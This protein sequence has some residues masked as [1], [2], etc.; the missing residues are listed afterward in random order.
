MTTELEYI[1]VLSEDSSFQLIR[2]NP[3]LTGNLKITVNEQ[4]G[5][6]LNSIPANLELA[7]DDFSRF[8]VDTTHSLSSNIYQFFKGGET[9][10]EIIF[11]LTEEVDTTK[12]SKD[13]KDQFDFSNYFSG[14]KYLVSSKYDER[15]SY[16]A[17]LYLK[18]EIPNYF[19]IFKIKDPLN[20]PIDE[21]KADYLA[22]QEKGD[23]LRDLFQKATI[24]KTFDLRPTTKIGKLIRDHRFSPNFPVSPLTVNF[25]EDQYTTWNGIVIDSGVLGSK[26]ELL[27][28]FYRA[29]SPLKFF[30]E[31]ITKGFERN[32]VII[33]N[34]L[35]LEFIFND[36]EAKLYDLDRYI[37]FYVNQIDL[38]TLKVDL[39]RAYAERETWENEPIF[40]R[41]YFEYEEVVVPQSNLNGVVLPYKELNFN[42]SEFSE[43]F[44]DRNKLYFNYLQ[45]RDDRFYLVKLPN[46]SLVESP[47]T[48]NYSNPISVTLAYSGTS[49]TV[50]L[51]NHSFNTDDFVVI[52]SQNTDYSGE[53]FITKLSNNTFSY[54]PSVI[55]SIASA[56]GTVKKEIG[57]GKIRLS[58]TSID[59]G[60]FFGPV[61][62]IFLQDTGAASF[63]A[64]YSSIAIKLKNVLN[65]LD[66]FKLYH[67]NGTKVDALGKYDFYTGVENYPLVQADGSFYAFNDYD[68][69]SGGDT[70]YFN[71]KG[72]V[73]EV[74][75]ALAGAI[76][77]TRNR[78]FIAY[79][80]EDYVFIRCNIP[81]EFDQLHKI[82]FTSPN[83]DYTTVVLGDLQDQNLVNTLVNFTGGSKFAGNRLV[84]NYGHFEKIKNNISNLLVK[85]SNG[86]SSISKISRYFDQIV[87]SNGISRSKRLSAISDYQQKMVIT[88]DQLT[89]PS[90]RYNNFLIKE[91]SRPPLGL[92]SFFPVKDLDFDFLTSTYLNFPQIDLYQN[93]YVPAGLELLMAGVQYKVIGGTIKIGVVQYADGD[94]FTVASDNTKYEIVLGNPTVTYAPNTAV[95]PYSLTYGISDEN[96]EL[97]DFPGFSILKDPDLVQPQDKTEIFTIRDKFINGLTSTEYDY[98]KENVATDFALRS[99]ILPYINKWAI[100]NGK[101]S[102]DNPYRLNTEIVFGRNN[103]SPDHTDRSQNPD[104]FTHEWFYIESSFNYLEDINT[105]KENN[106][107]FDSPLDINKL[108]TDEDYF[109]DYFTY[110]PKVI[111]S[112]EEVD[113]APTQFRYSKLFKNRAGRYET[114]FK[115]FKIQFNDV[116]DPNLLGADGRPQFN[117]QSNR[118]E[119]YKFSCILKP[120]KESFY[121][122]SK[123]PIKYEIIEHRD[124]KFILIV[125]KLYIGDESSIVSY[126]KEKTALYTRDAVTNDLTSSTEFFFADS[127]Y[128]TEFGT[129]LPYQTIL[130]DYRISFNGDGVSNLNYN[131]IYSLKNKKFNTKLDNFSNIKL[132][133]KI[134][135]SQPFI[136][137]TFEELINPQIQNYPSLFSNEVLKPS[138]KKFIGARYNSISTDYFIDEFLG[139]VPQNLNPVISVSAN[140]MQ[141]GL[142]TGNDIK[143]ASPVLTSP[144]TVQAYS[145]P[146]SAGFKNTIRDQFQFFVI[147]GGEQYFERQFENLSFSKFKQYVNSFD[148]FI[149]YSSY[150]YD[151]ALGSEVLEDDANFYLDILAQDEIYK[152][153]QVIPILDEDRPTQFSSIEKLSYVY[154][155]SPLS[156]TLQLNRYKGEYEPISVDLLNCNSTFKFTKNKIVDLSLANVSFNANIKNIMTLL[157]FN[158]IK[159]ADTKILSLESDESYLPKYS[160]IG[161]IAIGT[162][163]YF[164]LNSNWDWGFHHN[165]TT[166]TT[167]ESVSGSL[168]V[169]EDQC[170]LAKILNVPEIIELENFIITTLGV[171]ETLSGVNPAQVEMVIKEESN[172]VDGIININT[173]LTRYFI[174]NGIEAKF[175]EFLVTS[176]EYI[177]S[178]K[179][180]QDYVKAYIDQNI[181]ELYD[182]NTVEFYKKIDATLTSSLAGSNV[183]LI[184]F[185]FLSD[186]QR[187]DLGY[188][189]IKAIEINKLDK[190]IFRFSIIKDVSS[191]FYISP[192]VKIKFI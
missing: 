121:D 60:K 119:G 49:V 102:R 101:D 45:D 21:I 159:V 1:K 124:F 29:S 17:P 187:F 157:N 138:A 154:E 131:L 18:D 106:Y 99:K 20:K 160:S 151:S 94:F 133:K 84:I 90:V 173:V 155:V 146:L 137:N 4:D 178:Y 79:A 15:L 31:N 69:V 53:F 100:K 26:G 166:K 145:L 16:F 191:G 87:E 186:T 175:N 161:E 14:I 163:D 51:T 143:L 50:T 188:S 12:T 74:A 73:T 189:Q 85:T 66:E 120:I 180:I 80:F 23:Y 13:Y 168:R 11:Q 68:G 108:L 107:Y 10:N 37:G 105:I 95:L 92:L 72:L 77:S 54:T 6:W 30:E 3:K 22:G 7:K 118:F 132:S 9:P 183:N 116:T 83:L 103:F 134:D 61:N 111:Q 57:Q 88:L 75:S 46:S 67:P 130:G 128:S 97:V 96:K 47:Y 39:D 86:W 162:A 32:G 122:S 93:Y 44:K 25:S 24:V 141:Y 123:P 144:Y 179:T 152:V 110:T 58:N 65:H 71:C 109:I 62:E 142:S 126:W 167:Y 147:G 190:L 181:L 192:K 8:P 156:N 40:R 78:T 59:F 5:I 176:S 169:E 63:E 35:N 98:Y 55:P 158:H 139:T 165:W 135:L 27:Y 129:Q 115:G 104:T 153:S 136:A 76:N 38:A 182:I 170:Y 114:F 34:I 33:P 149:E 2:T 140:T 172:R 184:S 150:T 148:Q 70:F 127:S 56:I 28:D 64:G 174:E 113:L 19:I 171:T 36:D 48:I 82:K 41:K 117:P 112:G 81:G 185:E 177:G 43:I 89:S 164:L 125:I 52:D 42:L 91:K